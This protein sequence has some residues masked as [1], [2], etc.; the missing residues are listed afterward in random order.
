MGKI[1][2]KY[3]QIIEMAQSYGVSENAL[4]V[5]CAEQ[6]ALQCEV[7]DLIKK[8]IEEEDTLVTEKSYK[9]GVM[10]LYANPL[11]R[12]LPKHSDS[13]NKT[14]STM[15]DIINKLGRKAEPKGKLSELMNE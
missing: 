7:I 14:L 15:I 13:A 3:E 12:E 10:N 8:A 11:V 2:T 9:S 4:F 5:S 6:Y 1:K